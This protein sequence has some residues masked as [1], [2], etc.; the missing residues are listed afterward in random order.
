MK[1]FA[2]LALLGLAQC[3][4]ASTDY[5]V[6]TNP[7]NHYITLSPKAPNAHEETLIFLHGGGM[8]ADS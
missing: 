5:D 4:D 7:D 8:T 1:T 3:F 6:T 2:Y